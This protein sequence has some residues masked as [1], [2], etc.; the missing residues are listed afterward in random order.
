MDHKFRL[1]NSVSSSM[2][3]GALFFSVRTRRVKEA[4]RRRTMWDIDVAIGFKP[5]WTMAKVLEHY[6]AGWE[7]DH[8]MA[9]ELDF[10][11]GTHELV[12]TP[13]KLVSIGT[14]CG[15][16]EVIFQASQSGKEGA[17]DRTPP[18]ERTLPL[19]P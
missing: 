14:Q 9:D 15:D 2:G 3:G 1:S 10:C 4:N 8:P 7:D 6:F 17:P 18:A 11:H 5:G 19:Q 16:S 12:G 13:P